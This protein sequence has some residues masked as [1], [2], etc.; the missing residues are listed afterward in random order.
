MGQIIQGE[1]LVLGPLLKNNCCLID[2]ELIRDPERVGLV[3]FV[4]SDT[5]IT[6]RS[7]SLNTKWESKLI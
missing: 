3:T 1:Y 6:D 4:S 7:D 2:L 5:L